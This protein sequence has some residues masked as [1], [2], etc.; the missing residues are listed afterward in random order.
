MEPAHAISGKP[1]RQISSQSPKV[2]KICAQFAHLQRLTV[3]RSQLFVD[4]LARRRQTPLFFPQLVAAS[5][6][7]FCVGETI[8]FLHHAPALQSFEI[9]SDFGA[10]SLLTESYLY[11]SASPKNRNLKTLR[12]RLRASAGFWKPIVPMLRRTVQELC[13]TGTDRDLLD[14]LPGVVKRLSM[15]NDERG[16]GLQLLDLDRLQSLVHLDV[17]SVGFEIPDF[18]LLGPLSA[19]RSLS[20][21]FFF[22]GNISSSFDGM[23]ELERFLCDP[24]NLVGL[25]ALTLDVP[26]APPKLYADRMAAIRACCET[27]GIDVTFKP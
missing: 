6:I 13:V 17:D 26:G 14:I 5:L 9:D 7:G 18:R 23:L 20:L 11:P 8:H 4:Y 3:S 25:Q 1:G 2:I 15:R 24:S 27:R 16:A 19:L 22:F 10:A 21:H 12:S